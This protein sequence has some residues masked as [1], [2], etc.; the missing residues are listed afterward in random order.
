MSTFCGCPMP[1]GEGR[2]LFLPY[3]SW[4]VVDD[5][6]KARVWAGP[7]VFFLLEWKTV[8]AATMLAWRCLVSVR[9]GVLACPTPLRPFA[10]P[11]LVLTSCRHAGRA[12]SFGILLF[13]RTI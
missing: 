8:P 4:R 10:V 9:L 6:R 13:L 7:P 3:R 1:R 12:L 11:L 5:W 2:R